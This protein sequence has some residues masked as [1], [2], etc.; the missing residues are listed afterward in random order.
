MARDPATRQFPKKPPKNSSAQMLVSAWAFKVAL[1]LRPSPEVRKVNVCGLNL[2]RMMATG[3]VTD[4][5]SN[6][7]SNL[8][9]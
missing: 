2:A 8:N 4:G 1:N 5:Y 7:Q 3:N 9:S 6:V